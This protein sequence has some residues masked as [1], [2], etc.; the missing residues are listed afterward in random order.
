M[1]DGYGDFGTNAV[2]MNV[3]RLPAG[4]YIMQLKSEKET[5]TESFIKR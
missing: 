4:K 2:Q 1:K 5:M 3:S